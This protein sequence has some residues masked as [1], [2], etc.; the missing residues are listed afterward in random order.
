MRHLLLCLCCALSLLSH[1]AVVYRAEWGKAGDPL[2]GW[3]ARTAATA[4]E[5]A[6]LG[7]AVTFPGGTIV[8]P[9]LPV[10]GG[11]YYR[12]A[13]TIYKSQFGALDCY[14]R[15]SAKGRDTVGNC[16]LMSQ[17]PSIGD[18]A[19]VALGFTVEPETDAIEF[20][21][22]A[23]APPGQQV[24]IAGFTL[25]DGGIAPVVPPDGKELLPDPGW[26]KMAPRE[27]LPQENSYSHGPVWI[28]WGAPISRAA[29]A[30]PSRVHAGDRALLVRSGADVGNINGLRYIGNIPAVLHGWYDFSCWVKGEGTAQP[31]ILTGGAYGDSFTF[32]APT[33]LLSPDEWRQVHLVYHADNPA[34]IT[35]NVGLMTQGRVCLDDCSVRLITAE[36]ARALRV[37]A[38]KW[39]PPARVEQRVPAGETRPS[40]E[41]VL[42]NAHLRVALSPVGGGH[43]TAL[44]DK[45]HRRAWVGLDLLRL[46]FPAQ[47]VLVAWNLPFKTVV[48][49]GSVTFSHTATGGA[50][51]PFLDGLYLESRFTLGKDDRT[52]TVSYRLY[53]TGAGARL[54]NPAVHNSWTPEAGI[55]RLSAASADGAAVTEKETVAIRELAAGWMA[56]SALNDSLAWG[57]DV[58][59]AQTGTLNPAARSCGW[60][61]LRLTLPPGGAWETRA[62]LAPCPL[63]AVDYA[64]NGMVASLPLTAQGDD[65]T[66][67]PRVA[68]LT[69][70]PPVVKTVVMDYG[71]TPLATAAPGETAR[72]TVRERFISRLEISA[73]GK[74]SVVELF[75]DPRAKGTQHGIEG[76][77]Q[78]QYRPTVPARVLRLPDIGDRRAIIAKSKTVLWLY[79]L[80]SQYYPLE[81]VLGALGCAVERVESG[82]GL[83]EEVEELLAYRAIVISN[84]G[85]AHLTADGR[86]A[87]AQYVRAGGRLLVIGGSLS[88][89]NGQTTGT[90]LEELLPASLSGPFDTRPLPRASQLLQPAPK[91]PFAA[92]PW[93]DAPRLYWAH[94]VAPRPGAALLLTANAQ[95]VL[96]D[97]PCA[98]GTV[99]L[100]AATVEGDPQ[101]PDTP[102]WTWNGWGS[103]WYTAL[104]RLL[105]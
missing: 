77:G 86:A 25:D 93:K 52:L 12:L 39:A 95:P 74:T 92:L 20:Y 47:P 46:D 61:Y 51:A 35:F 84:M 14:F 72:F 105:K 45:D 23:P 22:G 50:A 63:P 16:Y 3:T 49:A 90:D 82:G 17:K 9:K 31:F 6:K 4:A 37:D 24:V 78:L 19:P 70:P 62:W 73:G 43:V 96:L 103:L 40:D 2:A 15:Q 44:T 68:P 32:A 100:Y 69:D 57:F 60:N 88:L 89:G 33:S 38:Y 79:G 98:R 99:M 7:P 8:S 30:L 48:E 18:H 101:P 1:A 67:A 91:S 81:Q 21:I 34:H 55:V 97:W 10:Q 59:A 36:E 64:G 71:G 11:H 66:V 27:E 85:A 65:F 29:T 94:R 26:E 5:D 104:Q 83:P 58:T 87:L 41:V 13:F 53:N 56:A 80:F 54:P 76:A 102:A 75:N 42:E 28:G